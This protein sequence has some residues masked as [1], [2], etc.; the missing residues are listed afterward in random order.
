MSNP[1]SAPRVAQARWDIKDNCNSET[2]KTFEAVL[3]EWVAD[4]T[5]SQIQEILATADEYDA[6]DVLAMIRKVVGA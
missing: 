6:A 1:A 3:A 4:T 2:L 5:K